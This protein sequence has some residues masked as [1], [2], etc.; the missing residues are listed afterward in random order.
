MRCETRVRALVGQPRAVGGV[1][2]LFRG[3]CHAPCNSDQ[4]SCRSIRLG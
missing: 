2:A 4:R 3:A 1:A